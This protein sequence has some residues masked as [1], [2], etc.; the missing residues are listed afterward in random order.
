MREG[1]IMTY[2]DIILYA[3]L[4]SFLIM[5][6]YDF[7]VLIKKKGGPISSA[8]FLILLN[9]IANAMIHRG[10]TNET[11]VEIFFNNPYAIGMG[12]GIYII[13]PLA[14]F[15]ILYRIHNMSV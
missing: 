11:E 1:E 13:F 6:I 10:R 4:T 5:I 2:L 12:V 9:I 15:Y 3:C 7:Q 8:G 14:L